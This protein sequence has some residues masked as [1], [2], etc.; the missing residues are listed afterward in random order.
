MGAVAE[1]WTRDQII[2]TRKQAIYKDD[3]G[4]EWIWMP[5]GRGHSKNKKKYLDEILHEGKALDDVWDMPVIT[6]SAKERLGY[7]TQ[8]PEALLERIIQASSNDGGVVLDPFCGCGTAIAVAQR[9]NRRWIGI[10][11]TTLAISLIKQRLRDAYG[12]H[13]ADTYNATGEPTTFDDAKGLAAEK[14]RYQFQWWALG[15]VEA[16]P[17]AAPVAE[18]RKKGADGGIDGRRSFEDDAS[19]EEKHV[20]ISV[21]SGKLKMTDVTSLRG[22]VERERAQIGVL[23][24]LYPPTGPMQREANEAGFYESPWKPDHL[25]PR[26]QILTIEE[27]MAG[28]QI[29]MPQTEGM[30]TTFKRAPK[31]K[32]QPAA[33]AAQLPLVDITC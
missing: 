29:D 7:P 26:L 1:P 13:V 19:D 33:V 11:V 18:E 31:A 9:L 22:V 8:K 32:R 15:L 20:L 14:D 17:V 6:S 23:I 28:K 12:G 3:T 5:G 2:R 25:Y 30:N 21:K 4:R 24:S 10:D 16:A 27:L